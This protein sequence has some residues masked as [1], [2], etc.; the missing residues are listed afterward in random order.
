LI[1][2]IDLVFIDPAFGQADSDHRMEVCAS[3]INDMK[4]DMDN[5]LIFAN[6]LAS[7]GIFRSD[8]VRRLAINY[9]D[10]IK[11]VLNEEHFKVA[12][13]FKYSS[14]PDSVSR[15]KPKYRGRREELKFGLGVGRGKF[16]DVNINDLYVVGLSKGTTAVLWVLFD[17]QDKILSYCAFRNGEWV[18]FEKL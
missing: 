18:A 6:Y 17:E 2:A 10:H 4:A 9:T 5:D 3:L 8:S 7:K 14:Y 12:C 11:S 1:S 13:I 16:I 15:F